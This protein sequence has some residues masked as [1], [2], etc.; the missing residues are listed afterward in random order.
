[1]K[2]LRHWW[3]V[4]NRTDWEGV[5]AAVRPTLALRREV[6]PGWYMLTVTIRA[7]QRRCYG[8]FNGTQGRLLISGRRRRRLVRVAHRQAQFELAGTNGEVYLDELRLVRQPLWR[9]HRLINNKLLAMHP[10][11]A[12]GASL[13]LSFA[14][15]W[16]EYNQI[17]RAHV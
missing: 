11:Y 16:G 10:A 5:H 2:W 17:G 14:R 12:T 8:I 13:D 4:F 1:M 9:V 15:L 7:E 3:G 6:R